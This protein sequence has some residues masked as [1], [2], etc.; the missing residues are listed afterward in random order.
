MQMPHLLTFVELVIGMEVV[1]EE[2]FEP[3]LIEHIDT[4]SISSVD[5]TSVLTPQE[6]SIQI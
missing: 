4:N 2:Y 5:T 6:P 1:S 3:L